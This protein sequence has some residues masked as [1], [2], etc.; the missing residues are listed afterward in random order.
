MAQVNAQTVN[1]DNKASGSDRLPD[2]H[3]VN[4]ANMRK[5]VAALRSG[6]FKQTRE[7]LGRIEADGS[8]SFCCLG[9]ACVVAGVP[10]RY[11]RDRPGSEH[12]VGFDEEITRLPALVQGWLGLR[13][14]SGNPRIPEALVP[15]S[16]TFGT[17]SYMTLAGLNDWLQYDFNQIAD[18][19]EEMYEL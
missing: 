6:E 11:F 18:V 19:L 2:R 15:S 5:W 9:V 12:M 7:Q 3:G 13:P 10:K 17:Y 8:E 14:N 1:K 4:R 16:E